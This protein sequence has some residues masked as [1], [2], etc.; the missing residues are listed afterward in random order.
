MVMFT[1]IRNFV[2]SINRIDPLF[3]LE[4]ASTSILLVGVAL[5]SANIYPMNI[6]F[7]LAGN[8]GWLFVAWAWRK[9]SIITVQ[10]VITVIYLVGMVREL[11]F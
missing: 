9:W 3:I 10:A 2:S 4:W 5:T 1:S 7:S 11:L 6:Y 8:I